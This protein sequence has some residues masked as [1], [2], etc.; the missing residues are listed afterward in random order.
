MERTELQNESCSECFEGSQAL[1]EPH[2]SPASL[3]NPPEETPQSPAWPSRSSDRQKRPQTN[4]QEI[5]IDSEIRQTDKRRIRE[6]RH[7]RLLYKTRNYRIKD[8]RSSN[9]NH[10]T[11]VSNSSA[12]VSILSDRR[13]YR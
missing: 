12:V 4:P 3:A 2:G 6:N 11:D 9:R 8:K 7:V 1:A 10:P 5:W 13:A